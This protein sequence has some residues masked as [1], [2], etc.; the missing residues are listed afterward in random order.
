MLYETTNLARSIPLP[1]INGRKSFLLDMS[2][3]ITV[4]RDE[5][6]A[7]VRDTEA[8]SYSLPKIIAASACGTLIEWY[9][10]FVFGSLAS[11][12]A[13]KFYKTGTPDGDLIAWLAAFAV[14]FIVRPFGAIVFGYIGDKVGRKFTF[15]LTL[16]VMGLCTALVGCLPTIQDIGVTAGYLLIILRI[17]QGLAIGGEYGG[18]AT[19][20]AEY[21]PAKH[22]GF[23]TSFIQ[24]TATAGLFLS[25]A[26]I[27]ICKVPMG[28]ALFNN[29]GWRLPFLLSIV[30]VGVSLYIRMALDESPMFNR[31][32]TSGKIAKNPLV[33]SFC[34]TKNLYYV[35]LALFGATAGQGNEL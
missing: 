23:Y 32:K 15:T 6:Q 9:D 20:I 12:L 28:D 18:A 3:N 17:V 4:L 16:V 26:V 8:P 35:G 34:R 1:G 24:V 19:Y 13:S 22:R 29:W 7:T 27:L 14:G 2:G 31:M 25:L 21:S 5:S 33:E 10:F 30:L 11:T